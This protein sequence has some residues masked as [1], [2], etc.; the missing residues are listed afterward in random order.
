MQTTDIANRSPMS[1]ISVLKTAN[2]QPKLAGEL[3]SKTVAGMRSQSAQAP[4]QPADIS[5]ITGTGTIINTTA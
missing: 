5:G 3:I 2:E 4:A 1:G